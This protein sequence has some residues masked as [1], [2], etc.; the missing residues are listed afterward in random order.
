MSDAGVILA[1][2]SIGSALIFFIL[3]LMGHIFKQNYLRR[4]SLLYFLI[5]LSNLSLMVYANDERVAIPTLSLNQ[6]LL[7]PTLYIE[8][9]N[10]YIN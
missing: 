7:L 1:T 2:F 9:P 8:V 10:N 4:F 5:F 6:A 3:L